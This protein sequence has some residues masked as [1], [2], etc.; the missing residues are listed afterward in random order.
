MKEGEN[1]EKTTYGVLQKMQH[2]LKIK[3]KI[4]FF[5]FLFVRWKLQSP[6]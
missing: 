6:Q 1:S 3:A 2:L 5:F 4:F